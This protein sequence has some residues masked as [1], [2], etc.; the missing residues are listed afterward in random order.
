ME[1]VNKERVEKFKRL[2]EEYKAKRE[3]ERKEHP[4]RFVR[5]WPYELF[6]VECGEG[7]KSLYQPITDYINEYNKGKKDE[8]K[9]EIHQI[10]EKFGGLRY[11][12]NFTDEK[13]RNMIREAEA[14]SYNT[15]EV[16]G[17]YI[18]KPINENHWIYAEC[19]ECHDK[20]KKDRQ[21]AMDENYEKKI[22]EKNI[23]DE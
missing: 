15:C 17:K 3:M 12:V 1:K 9:I 8:Y 23:N 18:E 11:Y 21:K 5:K 20:W 16:C 13:L 10:K 6:G 4:E 14:K 7:W 22:I 19:Q 2:C